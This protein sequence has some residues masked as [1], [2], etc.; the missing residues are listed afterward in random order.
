MSSSSRRVVPQGADK[1]VEYYCHR[2]SSYEDIY[3]RDDPGRR[4]ELAAESE[5]VKK[6]AAGCRVL[7]IPC[8]TGYWLSAMASKAKSI[9]AAD[10]SH[11][12]LT[13]AKRKQLPCHV[14][15][16]QAGLESIP[17]RA[18]AFDLIALGF[19]FS[20]QPRQTYSEF[21]D[22]IADLAGPNG[23]I[24]MIDNNPTAEGD[25]RDPVGYDE[26]ENHYT[27]RRI[28]DNQE[29]VILKNYFSKPELREIFDQRF[30][31]ERLVY[32]ECYWSVVLSPR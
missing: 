28:E 13:E 17:F 19:W 31:I 25:T 18:A 4:Q 32:G 23:R 22:T 9:V 21:L 3:Y 10:I 12:M 2:A 11:Q 30:H 14:D 27:R 8:G 5:R 7:D 1:L 26:F 29:Y 16:V 15:W 6:L 20:H 24:W